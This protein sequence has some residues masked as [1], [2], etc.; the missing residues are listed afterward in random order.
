MKSII[1]LITCMS[2]LC[3]GQDNPKKIAGRI[4]TI[5]A[6]IHSYNGKI[7]N[8]EKRDF[9]RYPLSVVDSDR[10]HNNDNIVTIAGEEVKYIRNFYF[11]SGTTVFYD[12]IAINALTLKPLNGICKIKA[13]N[14]KYDYVIESFKNGSPFLMNS[15]SPAVYYQ[16]NSLVKQRWYVTD[17]EKDLRKVMKGYAEDYIPIAPDQWRRE[18]RTWPSEK[19]IVED[20]VYYYKGKMYI[21]G[22]QNIYD[23]I[24]ENKKRYISRVHSFKKGKLSNVVLYQYSPNRIVTVSSDLLNKEFRTVIDDNRDGIVYRRNAYILFP[25]KKCQYALLDFYYTGIEKGEQ[26]FVPDGYQYEYKGSTEKNQ[27]TDAEEILHYEK[28]ILIKMEKKSI[29]ANYTLSDDLTMDT[30]GKPMRVKT[31]ETIDYKNKTKI[32]EYFSGSDAKPIVRNI[33]SYSTC[34][35]HPLFESYKCVQQKQEDPVQFKGR[36]EYYNSS[37]KLIFESNYD[38]SFKG[39]FEEDINLKFNKK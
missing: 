18:V 17:D 39:S 34:I 2:S 8:G 30:Y 29:N 1:L 33:I 27:P 24:L 38:D 19:L 21:D 5:F 35:S 26:C 13:K 7:P 12:T 16:S 37:G 4:D 3:F 23:N 10:M 9:Y 6:P 11:T 28:G 31:I 25:Q 32:R 36:T 22:L 14:D 15:R 20:T